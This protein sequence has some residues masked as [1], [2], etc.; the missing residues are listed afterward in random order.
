M[1][2]GFITRITRIG[3]LIFMI[4]GCGYTTRSM[5]SNKFKTIYI[6]PFVNKVDI[7]NGTYTGNQYRI[8]RPTLESDVTQ[9]V[10]RRFLFD[11]NLRP[12]KEEAADLALKGELIEFR[13]DPLSYSNSDTVT[14]YRLNI[15]VN[16]SLW[17][18]KENKLV[19]QEDNFTGNTTYFTT[20]SNAKTEDTAITDALSDLARRIVE[21]TV[22][23][24]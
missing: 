20:G 12:V 9:S 7:A 14:E 5:I 4:A 2:H 6:T 22:E 16:I 23:Q 3:L 21:R 13:R 18:K 17:D 15:V 24:W 19:W 1:S 11:G 10:I 8:Y